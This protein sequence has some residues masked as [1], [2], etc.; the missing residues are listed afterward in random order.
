MPKGAEGAFPSG[1]SRLTYLHI[2]I[3]T[4]LVGAPGANLPDSKNT[5][6]GY[7]RIAFVIINTSQPYGGTIATLCLA[8]RRKREHTQAAN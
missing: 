1:V 2:Y 8:R 6:A 4:R 7:V 5:S 3:D